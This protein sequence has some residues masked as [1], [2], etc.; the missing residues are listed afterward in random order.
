[1]IENMFLQASRKGVRFT[2]KGQITVEDLWN[3]SLDELNSIYEQLNNV[4]EKSSS[5]SLLKTRKSEDETLDLKIFIVQYIF[6]VK[7]QELNE[8]KT[9]TEKLQKK[10]QLMAILEQKQNSELMGKSSEEIAKLID[11]LGD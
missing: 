11:E 9:R 6:E 8:R 1:M 10:N 3:L 2:Y 5:K 7:Q 4:L